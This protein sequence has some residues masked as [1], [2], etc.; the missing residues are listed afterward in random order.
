MSLRPTPADPN[1]QALPVSDLSD[2]WD[3]ALLESLVTAESLEPEVEALFADMLPLS[4]TEVP[5]TTA[6]VNHQ[7]SPQELCLT[8]I[9]TT[10][11]LVYHLQALVAEF[12]PHTPDISPHPLT[13]L[14]K[15]LL[16][17]VEATQIAIGAWG[18]AKVE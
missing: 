18:N 1:A 8:H 6:A 15:Q 2:L 16:T 7:P 12:V 17:A 10:K 4:L 3:A 11:A 5:N 14:T 9:A 13:R